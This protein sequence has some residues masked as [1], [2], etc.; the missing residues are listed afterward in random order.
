[1]GA[2][3]KFRWLD[4]VRGLTLPP[5]VKNVACWAA[6]YASKDGGDIH[7]GVG[8]LSN[9][10]GLSRD[11]VVEALS[12]LREAGLLERV[13]RGGGRGS[14]LS[15]EYALGWPEDATEAEAEETVAAAYA[16]ARLRR[17]RRERHR[18]ESRNTSRGIPHTNRGTAHTNRGAATPPEQIP[19]DH[20]PTKSPPHPPRGAARKRAENT[21]SGPPTSFYRKTRDEDQRLATRRTR[22]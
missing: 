20:L 21:P 6:T 3:Y 11:N 10:T 5:A 16:T 1:M 15:D 19:P 22:P 18:Y 2:G 13:R 9:A 12:A 7:P 4:V 17:Q 8:E 14:K